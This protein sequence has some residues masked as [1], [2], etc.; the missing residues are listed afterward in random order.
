M[1]EHTPIE[2]R[3]TYR[4]GAVKIDAE[5]AAFSLLTD[6]G[7]AAVTM[8]AVANSIGVAHRSLYNHYRDRSA[9]V[10]ALAARGFRCLTD[11]LDKV[12]SPREFARVF[13]GFALEHSNLYGVMMGRANAKAEAGS[14]LK[15]AIGRLIMASLKVL[16]PQGL[17]GNEIQKIQARRNVMRIWMTI[18]GALALHRSGMLAGRN[19][20]DFIEELEA[21]LF[22][23]T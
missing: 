6:K 12:T 11:E 7:L 2:R 14:V 3:E 10:D 20:D 13:A 18:H 4:H 22:D 21:I 19:D 17:A 5:E 16:A 15:G 23:V 1:S 9:L 8:R